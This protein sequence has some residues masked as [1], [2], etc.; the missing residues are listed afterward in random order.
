MIEIASK[1][2]RSFAYNVAFNI[3]SL[4][5]PLLFA[6]VAT[7]LLVRNLGIENYGYYSIVLAVIGFAFT[8]GIARTPAKYIPEKRADGRSGELRAL[9]SAAI[10]ITLAVAA[11]EGVGLAFLS[12][13]LV[14]RILGVSDAAGLELTK[15]IYL[16]SVIGAMIMLS[17]IFQSALQGIHRFQ[18]Y[19]F[20]TV[21]TSLFVNVG[22]VVLAMYEFPY[23]DIIVWNLAITTLAA[24]AFFI[25]AKAGVPEAPPP[26]KL[27]A[28]ALR[29]VGRFAA[30][31]FVYQSITSVFY[32]FER[33]Y[34]LRNFGP[35]ALTYYTIPLML[36]IYLHGVVLA[37]AQVTIP[38]F[39]ER[40]NDQAGLLAIYR[41]LTKLVVA[42]CV[43]FALFYFLLG[44]PLL[45]LWLGSDFA[46]RSFRLLV[47]DGASFALI[48]LL[49]PAWILSEAA[50]RPGINASS[51]LVTYVIG[52]VA[53]FLLGPVLDIDGVASGR[54]VGAVAALPIIFIVEKLVFGKYLWPLWGSIFGQLLAASILMCLVDMAVGSL[55]PPSWATFLLRVAASSVAFWAILF[56][57]RFTNRTELRSAFSSQSGKSEN[58]EM[59]VPMQ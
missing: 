51:P 4:A 44:G 24:A 41:T 27:D 45:E 12:P 59:L 29:K 53:I 48:A 9:L 55:F 42:G 5:A 17:Q 28:V 43:Y 14:S 20:I 6:F 57:L 46:L 7:P 33:S 30:S 40:L 32:L 49:I 15:A 36:G 10:L 18:I 8:T 21:A 39:N 35:E 54:F 56:A 47:I 13:F 38:K 22:S 26:L 2:G 50:R 31:I 34:V 3:L 16:A 25:F 37:V 58:S 11:I 19:A 52:M 23:R 1:S